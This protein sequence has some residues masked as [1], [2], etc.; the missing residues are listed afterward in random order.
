MQGTHSMPNSP[1]LGR[2]LRSI[3]LYLFVS[4]HSSVA[5]APFTNSTSSQRFRPEDSG[6]AGTKAFNLSYDGTGMWAHLVVAWPH[7][8]PKVGEMVHAFHADGNLT[9]VSLVN[10]QMSPTAKLAIGCIYAS[11]MA[12]KRKHIERKTACHRRHVHILMPC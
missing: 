3:V 2:G 11:E 10:S 4:A 5:S 7:G 9:V 12:T 1:F 8:V 6:S